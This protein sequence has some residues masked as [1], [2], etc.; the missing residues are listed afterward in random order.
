MSGIMNYNRLNRMRA[1]VRHI[2]L[3]F[4][5]KHT[6][7]VRKKLSFKTKLLIPVLA[8]FI[9]SILVISFLNYRRLNSTVETKT[10]AILEIFTDGILAG[11]RHLDFILDE[12]KQTLKEKH[13]AIAKTVV[14]ILDNA[15]RDMTPKELQR[16]AEP[17][18]IFELSVANS[19][20][21]LT[22][23]SIPKYIGFDYKSTES[24]SVYMQ[25]TDGTLTELSEEP[26]ASVFNNDVG[27]INHY[28]GIV[29]KK[30][31][32]IQI[33]FNASVIDRLRGAIDIARTLEVTKIGEN[34]FGMLLSGGFI[35]A[36]PSRVSGL[37]PKV[38]GN[39]ADVS[40]E[41]WYKT[42]SSGNGFAWISIAGKPYYAGY[43]NA[44]GYTVVGL[45]PKRDFYRERNK[46]LADSVW[47]LLLAIAIMC[48]VT[49]LLI[50][51]LLKPVPSLI[52]GIGKITERNL[53]AKIENNYNNYEFNRIRDA[54][55]TMAATLK[56]HMEKEQKSKEREK[57]MLDAI[58]LGCQI[59]DSN[60]DT[61]DC[62][63]TAVRL[64][65]YKTKEEFISRWSADC[66]PEYQP[67][68][69]RS[70]DFIYT[71]RKKAIEEGWC[72][73]ALMHKLPDGTPLPA[74]ITLM[75]V[76]YD[77][78]FFLVR[79]TRDLREINML[80]ETVR[81]LET[82]ANKIY[83]DPLTDIYN[84]RFLDEN[85]KRIISTLS[86]SGSALGFMMI[87]IDHFKKYNDTYGHD[88]GD[89]CLKAVAETLTKSLQRTDD[90]VVRFGGEEFAVV[91]PNTDESGARLMADK[92]LENVRK[93]GISHEK[94]DAANCV[95]IS[96]GVATGKVDVSHNG[97]EY[98]KLADEML[99]RSKGEG[100]NR[101]TLGFIR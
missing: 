50:G 32:F 87:D 82:K 64:F 28:S 19:N 35:T 29:R 62:N 15:P 86:R 96:V 2:F 39:A 78:T 13:L 101:Y 11:S 99:Y 37:F 17:L 80:E 91:L 79:S 48:T 76:E 47:L 46:L 95:T 81:Q 67:N 18:D 74:E 65:G 73:F 26:R 84:R 30:G 21:I 77:D 45:V 71:F 89:K 75:R 8:I 56:T 94:N 7:Y 36:C 68:G 69:Q 70:Y 4:Q 63:D 38:A 49:Y 72:S 42:V 93:L 57:L 16:L 5:L 1:R 83:L 92:L 22:A 60:L 23:S 66:F 55:N 44:D 31:G 51:G 54:I 88:E 27:D 10:N 41:D 14:H 3:G 53:D 61:I 6:R 97:N 12:T 33:G 40:G 90:F 43:K 25:L 24:T 9:V 100:R 59:I 58:P 34:G 85:L 98:M 52:E 20:G